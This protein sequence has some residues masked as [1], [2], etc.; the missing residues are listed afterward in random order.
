MFPP[1]RSSLQTTADA[2]STSASFPYSLPH[3][4]IFGLPG[5]GQNC[6]IFEN[7]ASQMTGQMHIRKYGI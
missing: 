7:E 3:N 5:F 4:K 1:F 2:W 6:F